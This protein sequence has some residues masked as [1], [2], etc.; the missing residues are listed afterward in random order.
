MAGDL[1]VGIGKRL[2]RA[3]PETLEQVLEG[4]NEILGN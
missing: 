4:L 2:G 3:T 1:R